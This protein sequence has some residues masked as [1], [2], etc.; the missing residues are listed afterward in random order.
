MGND[1]NNDPDGR[2]RFIKKA[3]GVTVLGLL[4][5][6][7]LIAAPFSASATAAQTLGR[8]IKGTVI[9][10][11]ERD[12]EIWRA[13]T[14]WQ[15]YKADRKP[16][17]IVRVVDDQDVITTVQF[18][19]Q[20]GLKVAVKTGGHSVWASFLR[21]GGI[22]L[23]LSQLTRVQIDPISRTAWAQPAIYGY[24]LILET[25][26]HGLA[27]PVAHC[28]QLG[29]GGFL[30]GGGLG[31]NHESW[32]GMSCFS[33]L[34]A[35]VVT[36]Q[37]QLLKVSAQENPDLFWAVRGG[38]PGFP[39]IV[40]RYHL[41]LYE[42]PTAIRSYT[43]IFP[44][45]MAVE[46]ATWADALVQQGLGSTEVLAVMTTGPGGQK[47]IVLVANAFANSDEEVRRQLQ[48]LIDHPMTARAVFKIEHQPTDMK[49]ILTDSISAERGFGF[50]RYAV[51]TIWTSKPE[52]T[53][54]ALLAQVEQMPSTH[55]HVVLS[56]KRNT[57]L[58][59]D[60][61]FS[62]MDR[63]F[64][65]IYA[66]WIDEADNAASIHWLRQSSRAIQPLASGHYINEIDLQATPEKARGC[67][68][69]AAW[70]RLREI[71]Q[72]RDPDGL[73]VDFFGL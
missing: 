27:F 11:G 18:A 53:V 40:T 63:M 29:L 72:Q 16:A 36:A 7:P 13:A 52:A 23:D 65:G 2:R 3:M 46:V 22:L 67:F 64:A 26:K 73:L 1:N 61:A 28:A 70:K 4:P 37:G 24:H 43:Y 14:M 51:D 66:V 42:M 8:L 25:E 44:L 10:E 20:Q 33:I 68:S 55:S 50:G 21:D 19:R 12:Y 30:L 6:A 60:A 47:V 17:L 9:A 35:E 49:V 58:P 31:L 71:R 62:T 57:T 15:R 48:S 59:A 54:Q 39:G 32:G 34:G 5:S 41:K 56:F 38:G 45:S 69:P